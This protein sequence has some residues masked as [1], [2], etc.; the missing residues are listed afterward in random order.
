MKND[1]KV[2]EYTTPQALEKMLKDGYKL[3]QSVDHKTSGKLILV[4]V[5]N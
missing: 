2:I 4:L 5:K 1:V 3:V